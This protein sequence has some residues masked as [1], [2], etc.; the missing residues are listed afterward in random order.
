MVR[1]ATVR[2]FTVAFKGQAMT[3]STIDKLCEALNAARRVKYPM[4]GY[5]FFADVKG[6]GRRK[7]L[8]YIVT[9]KNGGVTA[10]YNGATY[11]ETAAN[12]RE[13]LSVQNI[14]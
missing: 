10:C 9:N 6:D 5:T 3:K 14:Y 13:S 12:L 2:L 7:R 11:R 8:V 1:A 4:P